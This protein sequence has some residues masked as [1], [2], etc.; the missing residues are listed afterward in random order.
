MNDKLKTEL[1]VYLANH[2]VDIA[3]EINDYGDL[4]DLFLYFFDRPPKKDHF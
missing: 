4:T 2:E 1:M 3:N